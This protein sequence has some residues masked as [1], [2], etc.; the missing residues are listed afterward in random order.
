MNT[1]I[2]IDER[3]RSVRSRRTVRR[4]IRA[5]RRSDDRKHKP[6]KPHTP[7]QQRS[8]ADTTRQK[9]ESKGASEAEHLAR[10]RDQRRVELLRD[11]GR[12]EHAAEIIRDKAVAGPLLAHA[13]PDQDEGAP[14]V[15]AGVEERFPRGLLAGDLELDRGANLLELVP[16][17]GVIGVAFAVV[18]D[19][20][21]E[22]FFLFADAD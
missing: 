1:A 21:V 14:A 11:A 8:P 5:C 2:Q 4:L 16:D 12:F 9:R 18:L 13:A 15:A 3:D 20:D 17:D 19:E 6:H 22:G 10:S 7:K